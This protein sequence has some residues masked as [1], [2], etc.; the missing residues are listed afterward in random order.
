MNEDLVRSHY[1]SHNSMR[2]RPP[3][4]PVLQ[5]V[6][7]LLLL[8]CRERNHLT[9]DETSMNDGLSHEHQMKNIDHRIDYLI[10][11][12]PLLEDALNNRIYHLRH[13]R[14]ALVLIHKLP[15][16]LLADVFRYVSGVDRRPARADT[17][18]SLHILAQ[19]CTAWASV[20]K[21]SP[22]LWTIVHAAHSQADWTNTLTLSNSHPLTLNLIDNHWPQASHMALWQTVSKHI[23]R[24]ESASVILSPD[25]DV[26]S[27]EGDPPP[28]LQELRLQGQGMIPAARSLDLFRGRRAPKLLHITLEAVS[29]R[30]WSSSTLTGLHSLT[31]KN[32]IA[33]PGSSIYQFYDILRACPSLQHL[34]VHAVIFTGEIIALEETPR[35][36]LP[37]LQQLDIHCRA[38][39][40][41][42]IDDLVRCNDIKIWCPG[43]LLAQYLPIIMQRFSPCFYSQLT[44]NTQLLLDVAGGSVKLRVRSGRNPRSPDSY[45]LCLYGMHGIPSILHKVID[46]VI[47]AP[48]VFHITLSLQDFKTMQIP[49]IVDPLWRLLLVES[50]EFMRC[51]R[52]LDALLEKLA[53]PR[54]EDGT[55]RWMFPHLKHILLKEAN[56]WVS[57]LL[58]DVVNKRNGTTGD[59]VHGG[60]K[61][62][63]LESI[64]ICEMSFIDQQAFDEIRSIIGSA[65][66]WDGHNTGED[67]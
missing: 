41:G 38:N 47:A 7:D 49:R 19:V 16:E 59:K 33:E 31:F 61:S 52:G 53:S 3:S 40:L 13:Q 2:T 28:A 15:V 39:I 11:A 1:D 54:W 57:K 58:L 56:G 63:R 67:N 66:V 30:N 22:A 24:W 42:A 36:P 12:T 62:D 43:I 9:D 18:E 55:E 65:V 35:I 64:R 50:L 20:V 14:T 17:I 60:L 29:L 27:L 5:Q 32:F 48:T 8:D 37:K 45:I 34:C 23:W 4:E 10:L 44:S 51:G 26:S 46:L 25:M 6:V 21:G